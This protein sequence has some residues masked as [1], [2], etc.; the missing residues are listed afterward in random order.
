MPNILKPGITSIKML[1]WKYS[2]F[3]EKKYLSFGFD[4]SRLSKIPKAEIIAADTETKLYH[5]DKILYEQEAYELNK[6]NGQAWTKANIEIRCYAFML[7]FEDKFAIF[8]TANDFLT[9]CA[10]LHAKKVFWYNAKFDF[11]IFD[12]FFLTNGWTEVLEKAKKGKREKVPDKSY[13]SLNGDFG[14]RYQLTIWKRYINN[15]RHYSTRKFKMLDIC[16]IYGGGLAKNLES[17]DIRDETGKPIRKLAMDYVEANFET[18]IEYMKADTKGLYYLAKK[19][20]KTIKDISGFSLFE[21]DF[22]TAGGL[23]KKSFLKELFGCDLPSRNVSMFKKV[24]PITVS[25]DE[26]FRED[27]L[28]KGGK[29][30]V[31]PYK[32][33]IELRKVYKYDVNSMYPDKMRNMLY[34]V[35]KPKRLKQLDVKEKKIY[36]LYVN[37][38]TGA[39]K[40]GMIGI[41]Q[42]PLTGDYVEKINVNEPL[43]FWKEELDELENWYDLKY[44]LI[45][46]LEYTAREVDGAKAYVDKFYKIKRESKGAIKQGAKLFLNSAYGKLAQRV[47]RAVC[48]YK[49]AN[50]GYVHLVK[51]GTETDENSMLSVVVGSRVTALARVDL[52]QKIRDVSR[53]NPRKYFVYCDTDSIHALIPYANTDPEELGKLKDEGSYD[54]A[55]YLAPKSYLMYDEKNNHFEV[56]CK[57]VNIGVVEKALSVCKNFK[58]AMEI[59][60]PNRTFKCLCGINVK[61]GKALIYVDKM[62]LND[63]NFI[64]EIQRLQ[65]IEPYDYENNIYLV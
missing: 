31:N 24:F 34:P 48:H 28:Y 64:D 59:F 10:M 51:E 17:F 25:E 40:S 30:F 33:G 7:A 6:K 11:A 46:A 47:D 65:D 13:Q 53:G 44:D 20:D 58:E 39:L 23:A 4:F 18:D 62:I 19:I 22:I 45:Y 8:Q 38:L 49:L 29:C 15:T 21:G 5:N 3:F 36:I 37:N 52:M 32:K 12:Y 50:E 57:G 27:G 14:Q 16:N 61:G 1:I 60:K 54:Y 42:D 55:V 26:H 35:G 63:D 9:A 43:F 41:Y 2:R 56:H